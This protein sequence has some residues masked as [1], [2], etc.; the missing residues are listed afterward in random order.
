MP[1]A[2]AGEILKKPQELDDTE[3]RMYPF[4]EKY[5]SI[6]EAVATFGRI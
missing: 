6:K 4:I 1:R 2:H 3:H 5:R